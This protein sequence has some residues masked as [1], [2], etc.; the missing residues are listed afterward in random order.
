M[1]TEQGRFGSCRTL[2]GQFYSGIPLGLS[3]TFPEPHCSLRIHLCYCFSFSI[4]LHRCKTSIHVWR[5]SLPSVSFIF[6]GITTKVS[7][8][9]NFVFGI[10]FRRTQ[11]GMLNRIL[12][13]RTCQSL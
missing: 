2:S 4:S 7:C 11:I 3:Q 12:C 9:S 6:T 5:C 10:C 13:Y 1:T 8:D